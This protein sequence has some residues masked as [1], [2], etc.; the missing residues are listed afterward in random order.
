M[1]E[2]LCSLYLLFTRPFDPKKHMK[3][4]SKMCV[5]YCLVI[6]IPFTWWNSWIKGVV[7][8]TC[9][10]RLH[11]CDI[12]LSFQR[13]NHST[14]TWKSRQVPSE[15][16]SCITNLYSTSFNTGPT[17]QKKRFLVWF[18]ASVIVF[19]FIC[20]NSFLLFHDW[21]RNFSEDI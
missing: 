11:I 15:D 17:N 4:V 20:F 6:C 13:V 8:I 2:K 19:I 18:F 3:I 21:F 9:L 5:V 16:L 7:S 10:V 12:Y 14:F 1:N